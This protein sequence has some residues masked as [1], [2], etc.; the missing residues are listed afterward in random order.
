[1]RRFVIG[2]IHGRAEALEQCLDRASF[3][4]DDDL[5]ISLGDVCDRGEHTRE[6]IDLLL[7]IKNLVYILGN[8]DK[9]FLK[10]C[11]TGEHE[12]LWTA[13]GGRSTTRSYDGGPVPE[14]HIALLR[15]ARLYYLLDHDTRLFVHAGIDPDKPLE[16][17]SETDLL[18]TRLLVEKAMKVV[19]DPDVEN[20][21]PYEEVYV[22]HTPTINYGFNVPVFIKGVWMMDTGA[23]WWGK[24][25]IMDIDSK[26]YWQSDAAQ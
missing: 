12:P 14:D 13:Q 4:K 22:G 8:H 26:E 2:D 1:M 5:L 15:N 9:W 7:Q 17:Q 19:D 11:L 20:L 25:T 16:E 3:D 10:W 24:L 21:T 23:G 18:W 6:S